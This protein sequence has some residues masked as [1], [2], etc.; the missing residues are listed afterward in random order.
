MEPMKAVF[1]NNSAETFTPT[2]SGAIATHI[3]ECCRAARNR[4]IEPLVISIRCEAEPYREVKTMLLDYPRIPSHPALI[5]ALRAQRKLTGWRHLRQGAY[6]GRVAGAVREAGMESGTLILHNDPE[7]AVVLRER[8]PR[9]FIVHHFHNLLECKTRFRRRFK[10]AVNAIT[11]VSDFT[12]RWVEDYYRC[13]KVT[14]IYNGV[15]SERFVPMERTDD[16]VPVINFT[17]RTGIEKAPDL[18]LQAACRLT[19]RTKA[20]AIQILGSNHWQK[21]EWDEYQRTLAGLSEE[22]ERKGVRVH[23]PGHVQRESLPH[24]LQKADI[25]VVPSRWD[26]P[27]GL[28]TVEGMACGLAT[29]ASRTGGTPELVGN[30][31]L[32]FERDSVEELTNHLYELVTNRDLRRDLGKKARA[33]AQEFSWSRTWDSF[34]RLGQE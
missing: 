31:G 20:F 2:Q 30:A 28:V 5:K 27:F 15:D 17:G 16:F 18:L 25:H 10:N 32:L 24:N 22:L 33:R 23:R 14:T 13:G 9:A 1:I 4:G 21:F 12:S 8:F 19:E 34:S 7:L 11:A 29:V 3:W 6:A 26:E